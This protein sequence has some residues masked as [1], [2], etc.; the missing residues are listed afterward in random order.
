[1]TAS[2]TGLT[3]TPDQPQAVSTDGGYVRVAVTATTPGCTRSAVT[4]P[5]RRGAGRGHVPYIL[6]EGSPLPASTGS[7]AGRAYG[8]QGH[9]KLHAGLGPRGEHCSSFVTPTYA[10][11]GRAAGRAAEVQSA[12]QGLPSPYADDP[13]TGRVQVGDDIVG[14]VLGEGVATDGWVVADEQ[15]PELFASDT[16]A[17]TR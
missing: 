11:V 7:L 15:V 10:Y 9:E 1:M 2:G 3:A 8:W 14:K 16:E 5:P 12:G 13:T 4:L 6:A 17:P